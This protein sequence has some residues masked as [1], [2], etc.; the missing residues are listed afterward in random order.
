[1]SEY[2]H[3]LF[4]GNIPYR[5]DQ[6]INRLGF[7]TRFIDKATL[8]KIKDPFFVWTGTNRIDK[9]FSDNLF[10]KKIFSKLKKKKIK[11]F[12]YEPGCFYNL[13]ESFFNRSF[14]SEFL[15]TVPYEHMRCDALDSIDSFAE[16]YNL[17]ITV[18]TGDYN[19]ENIQ[20]HYKNIKVDCLDLFLREQAKFSLLWNQ[21]KSPDVI[22]RKLWCGNWR[23]TPHRHIVAAYTSTAD[24]QISWH[25]SASERVLN[26]VNWLENTP[27][28]S[29]LKLKTGLKNL[30]Q[31]SYSLEFNIPNWDVDDI[32][33]LVVIPNGNAP[34]RSSHFFNTYLES[35]CA[36]VNETRYAQPFANISEK[37]IFPISL[38]RPFILVAPPYSLEY[39]KKL[40]FKTFDKWWDES[41]DSTENHSVR[42][43]KIF[44]LIDFLDSKN[45][46]ELKE[47]YME[48]TDILEHNKSVL[49][50]L[51]QDFTATCPSHSTSN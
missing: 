10:P 8:E 27:V 26:D 50:L 23:Y 18:H 17:D 46:N 12:L 9:L 35:F 30:N 7:L 43:Q 41:Y 13:K 49:S 51:H 28:L 1:M 31:N 39:V 40:G 19:I 6:D 44:G 47:M 25:L 16:K 24:S 36:I 38:R 20:Q 21:S 11:F 33:N 5:K 42:M 45:L 34:H 29:S 15:D 14:Y 32:K 22:K 48:M 3:D 37:T 2:K 4:F